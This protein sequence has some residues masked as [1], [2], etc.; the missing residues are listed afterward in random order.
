M[1]EGINNGAWI[2]GLTELS[3]NDATDQ[4]VDRPLADCGLAEILRGVGNLAVQKGFLYAA[5]VGKRAQHSGWL[6]S[7]MFSQFRHSS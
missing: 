1:K 6:S 5:R 3:G 7:V 2:G 4:H